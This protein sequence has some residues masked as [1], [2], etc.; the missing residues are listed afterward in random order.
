M[1]LNLSD[2]EM[3][4]I[5]SVET[6]D[7]KKSKSTESIHE[8][9]HTI[10]NNDLPSILCSDSSHDFAKSLRKLYKKQPLKLPIFKNCTLERTVLRNLETNAIDKKSILLNI[11]SVKSSN[12]KKLPA[13]DLKKSYV[14]KSLTSHRDPKNFASYAEFYAVRCMLCLYVFAVLRDYHDMNSLYI[15]TKKSFADNALIINYHDTLHTCVFKC[16]KHIFNDQST[17]VHYVVYCNVMKTIVHDFSPCDDEF[18]FIDMNLKPLET[19]LV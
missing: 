2:N 9:L 3:N 12:S 1:K 13:I 16:V 7:R 10:I 18:K 8:I 6:V 17:S 19:K 5:D 15:T 14:C 11:P 4:S